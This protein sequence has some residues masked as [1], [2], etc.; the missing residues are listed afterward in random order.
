MIECGCACL[1][2]RTKDGRKPLFGTVAYIGPTLG[3]H[4]P[5]KVL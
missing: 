4:L 1:M 2:G 3:Y 5:L